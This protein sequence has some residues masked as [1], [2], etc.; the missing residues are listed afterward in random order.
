MIGTAIPSA[1]FTRTEV[2]PPLDIVKQCHRKRPYPTFESAMTACHI[3]IAKEFFQN[4]GMHI[5]TI[6]VCPHC[7]AFHVGGIW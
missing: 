1:R 6:Y 2:S 4:G 5:F 3:V 7:G